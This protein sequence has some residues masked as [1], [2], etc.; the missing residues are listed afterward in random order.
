[1]LY[2]F[3]FKW[4]RY[5]VTIKRTL[6]FILTEIGSHLVSKTSSDKHVSDLTMKRCLPAFTRDIN[7]LFENFFV[8]INLALCTFLYLVVKVLAVG[9]NFLR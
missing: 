1:M 2:G 8:W 9:D 4:L 7:N 3:Y 5:E 6:T